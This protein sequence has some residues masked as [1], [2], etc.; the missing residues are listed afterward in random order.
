[1]TV[2]TTMTNYDKLFQV[3]NNLD[4]D[5]DYDYDEEPSIGLQTVMI[6]TN[7]DKL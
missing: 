3:L 5:V 7:N 2:T 4:Y 6:M 1:M